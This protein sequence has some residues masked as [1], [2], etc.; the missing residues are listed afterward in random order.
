MHLSQ[1]P[2][3]SSAIAPR[4]TPGWPQTNRYPQLRPLAVAQLGVLS[5][6]QLTALDVSARRI[7]HEVDVRRW[8]LVAP[9]VVALQNAPLTRPQRMWLGVLHAGRSAALSHLTACELAGLR[10]TLD[11]T[12]HVLTPKGDLVSPLPGL[13]FRQT[14]RPY[15]DWV[16]VPSSP[17]RLSIEAAALLT[18]ERDR[19]LRR[20][21]GLVAAVVQQQLSTT[22]RL[23]QQA[24]MTRKLRNGRS[25]TLALQDIA[26]GAHSF[27]EI[28]IG[29]LC[30][31]AG[32]QAP[33]RQRL[34][35]DRQGRR[36]Y[37]DCEWVLP[38]GTVVVLEIDGSFHLRTEH[39]WRDM[40]RERAIVISGRRVLRCSSVELRLEPSEIIADLLAVGVPRRFVCDRPA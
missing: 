31:E 9:N 4:G 28:D 5:R 18:A 29:R 10:W 36:R 20:A 2:F 8:T 34:R 38:D 15:V 16:L 1:D 22:E 11:E 35:L 12:V 26:G 14:R 27:A 32:L 33:E 7:E 19:N 24:R 23:L 21:I 17:P 25:I 3:D 13:R 39:W 40:K 30:A 6:A 37:L